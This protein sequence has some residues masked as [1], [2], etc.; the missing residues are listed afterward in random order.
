M[1]PLRSLRLNSFSSETSNLPFS[2]LLESL[3]QLKFLLPVGIVF[4]R[5][6]VSCVEQ[7]ILKHQNIDCGAH[8]APVRIF[9]GA[10]DRLATHVERS[11]H[12]NSA[13][14]FRLERLQQRII[15]RVCLP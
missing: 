3:V 5:L 7:A 15:A 12:E 11:V 9:R 2:G 14:R 1:R 10:D 6:L 13:S 4:E 8:K